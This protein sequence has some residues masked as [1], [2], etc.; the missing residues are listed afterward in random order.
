MGCCAGKSSAADG[1]ATVNRTASADHQQPAAAYS[2]NN[3]GT[4]AVLPGAPGGVMNNSGM[5]VS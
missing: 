2:A 3:G 4:A 5:R 1:D